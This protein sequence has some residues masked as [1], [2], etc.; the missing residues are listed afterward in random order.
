MDVAANSHTH[1]AHLGQ[2]AARVRSSL[3]WEGIQRKRRNFV[4]R[5]DPCRATEVQVNRAS[6]ISRRFAS[7][8]DRGL[9]VLYYCLTY[10]TVLGVL[11]L[12]STETGPVDAVLRVQQWPEG[13]DKRRRESGLIFHGVVIRLLFFGVRRG[14]ERRFSRD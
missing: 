8:A 12:I 2:R 3:G 14:R 1:I 7:R 11:K 5:V 4:H 9:G 10:T 13:S 6:K